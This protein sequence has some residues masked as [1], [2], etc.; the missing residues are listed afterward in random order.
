VARTFRDPELQ[1]AFARDG[2]VVV[3]MLSTDEARDLDAAY[4]RLGPA[5]GDPGV[6]TIPSFCTW[7][8]GYKEEADRLIR[9]AFAP[10][11]ERHVDRQRLMP[12]NFVVK[13]PGD[14]SGFGL[15]QD[16]TLVDE[17]QHRSCEV[18]C[19]LQDTSRENGA[20]WVVPR[21][22]RW[23]EHLRGIH[24]FPM[25]C[26]G[27]EERVVRRHARPVELRAGEAIVFDHALVHF[28]FPNRSDR[29]RVA[30]TIDLIPDGAQHVHWF[31]DGAGNVACYEIDES[32]WVENT[33]FTLHREPQKWPV[34]DRTQAEF[35]PMTDAD[36]DELVASGLAIDV[37]N[38]VPERINAAEPWCHRCGTSEAVDGGV[39]PLSGNV[40]LLCA[41]CAAAEA[42]RLAG[43]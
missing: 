32:F 13:W 16:L 37:D 36:L 29:R 11:L 22:H 43:V 17:H 9:E 14:K 30:A 39:H 15:H 6:A 4:D 24:A 19:A 10:G 12:G 20:L 2:Y 28:S 26:S 8:E 38:E 25:V 5:P 1:A 18:W 23:R 31:G 34:V 21:S 7:D 3:P 33:P 40:T 41:T 42:S 27:L 35:E